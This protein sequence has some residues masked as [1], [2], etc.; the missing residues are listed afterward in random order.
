MSEAVNGK[1]GSGKTSSLIEVL[2]VT[3][4]LQQRDKPNFFSY[5]L[6]TPMIFYK[7]YTYLLISRAQSWPTVR[8]PKFPHS[9]QN[10]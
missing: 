10:G 3:F 1:N 2:V 9:I 8:R 5:K 6:S 7:Q 4:S